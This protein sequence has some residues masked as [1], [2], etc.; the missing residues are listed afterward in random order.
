M[1]LS[2]LQQ[3]TTQPLSLLMENLPVACGSKWS[4]YQ[5]S[6]EGIGGQDKPLM[7]TVSGGKEYR[8]HLSVILA[9]WK[10]LGMHPVLVVAL[11]RETAQTVCSLGYESV[12]WDVKQSSY[13]RVADAKFGVAGFLAGHNIRGLFLELDVFCRFSPLPLILDR[14]EENPDT[15]MVVLGHGDVNFNPNIGMFYIKP[16]PI[17]AGY[18]AS[19]VRVLSHS[20]DQERTYINHNDKVKEFFDQNVFYHCL[21]PTNEEDLHRK[22]VR[23]M[24]LHTDKARKNNLLEICK[25][26]TSPQFM[27]KTISHAYINSLFP[28]AVYDSTLCVHPLSFTPFSSLKHKLATAKFMGFDPQPVNTQK[29]RYLKTLTGDLGYQECWQFVFA[30]ENFVETEY[31]H[32]NL[33]LQIATLV[34]LA[35]ETGRTLVLPRYARD[36]DSRPVPLVALVD[37]VTIEE[38]VPYRFLSVEDMTMLNK[39]HVVEMRKSTQMARKDILQQDNQTVVALDGFCRLLADVRVPAQIDKIKGK[40]RFCMKD[41]RNV[42]F[43]KSI[44]GWSRLCGEDAPHVTP[45]TRKI[46]ELK[47]PLKPLV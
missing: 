5:E 1:D 6:L 4:D 37:I 40:L 18:F 35:L 19:L 22:A 26:N 38:L 10:S 21:P 27:H 14:M 30:S 13:S 9:K 25:N 24:F 32:K 11:D 39:Q 17:L 31:Y 43:G 28:P 36:K 12:L 15:D 29:G 3:D 8:S 44:G 33:K 45:A 42:V 34:W 2:L 46:M 16:S 23:K 47:T 20:S 7:W 41:T